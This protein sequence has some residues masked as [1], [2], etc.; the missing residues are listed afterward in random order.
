VLPSAAASLDDRFDQP[1][2]ISLVQWTPQLFSLKRPLKIAVQQGR[3][4]IKTGSVPSWYVE[5]FG[6]PRTQLAAIFS[7]R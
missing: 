4:R 2:V 7:S 6:E 5:D 3:R 1:V